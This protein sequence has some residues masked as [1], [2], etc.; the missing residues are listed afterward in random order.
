MCKAFACACTVQKNCGGHENT[1]SEKHLYSMRK[2][3][4][5]ASNHIDYLLILDTHTHTDLI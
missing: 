5:P 3:P 1:V 2:R 4:M